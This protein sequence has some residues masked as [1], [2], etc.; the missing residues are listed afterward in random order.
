MVLDMKKK[1]Y[2]DLGDCEHSYAFVVVDFKGRAYHPV[3]GGTIARY[4]PDAD[5]LEKLPVTVDGAAPPR[6]ITKDGSILNW[7]W[8]PDKKTLYAVEMSTNQV[9]AFDLTATGTT[10]PGKSLGALLPKAKNTD[11]RAMCVGS[12]GKLWAAVSE[13]GQP[14]GQLLHLV[15]YTPG[16][17][18]PRDHGKVAIANPDYTPFTDAKGKP[19]PWHHTVRKHTDGT[20]APWQPMGVC[21]ARDG[22]GVYVLTIAPFTLLKIEAAKLK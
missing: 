2:R 8:S 7:D 5:K 14:G 16:Q 9:F 18:S 15:S 1:T 3:R 6:A 20:L 19:L 13:L 17:K 10:I 4:D 22:S 12:S 11:C 21:E